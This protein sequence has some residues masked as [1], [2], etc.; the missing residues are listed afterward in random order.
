[1]TT[2]DEIY[3]SKM[4][5]AKTN[6]NAEKKL[7]HAIEEVMKTECGKQV[8]AYII[9]ASG[10]LDSGLGCENRDMFLGSRAVGLSL[11]LKL[12]QTNPDLAQKVVDLIFVERAENCKR[13]KYGR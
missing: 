8:L 7:T 12:E 11:L 6:S 13:A 5:A 10:F 4:D 1:M 9:K 2:M 3:R